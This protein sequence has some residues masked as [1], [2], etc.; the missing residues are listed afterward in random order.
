MNNI[1]N[2]IGS[3]VKITQ[4]EFNVGLDGHMYTE[5]GVATLIK[6]A[7]FK[8]YDDVYFATIGQYLGEDEPTFVGLSSII[9]SKEEIIKKVED[10][11]DILQQDCIAIL[12]DNYEGKLI[13]NKRH[14]KQVPKQE[15]D[16]DFFIHS[17]NKKN[18][19]KNYK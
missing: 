1:E 14:L 8:M 18:F 15:F 11:C 17:Y 10:L 6:Q 12:I 13:Y 19:N 16:I 5:N 9:A 4:V 3:G 7:G 2:C